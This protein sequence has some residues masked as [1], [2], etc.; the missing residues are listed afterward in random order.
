MPEKVFF[1]SRP[2]SS[3]VPPRCD[4]VAAV[5]CPGVCLRGGPGGVGGLVVRDSVRESVVRMV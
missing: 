5:H 3:E 4:P 2:P 1:Q